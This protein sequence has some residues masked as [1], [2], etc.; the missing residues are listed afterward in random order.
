MEAKVCRHP[1]AK[2]KSFFFLMEA[3]L[4]ISKHNSPE[5]QPWLGT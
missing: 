4:I 3:I 2:G 1:D 5:L